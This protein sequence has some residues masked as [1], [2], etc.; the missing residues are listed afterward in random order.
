[1]RT[2]MLAPSLALALACSA[3]GDS[4]PTAKTK[5]ADDL[6]PTD[7]GADSKTDGEAPGPGPGDGGSSGTH[8]GS[9]D[10]S[11][12]DSATCEE[13]IIVCSDFV[14]DDCDG[15]DEPCP[16]TQSAVVIPAWDCR[17]NPPAGVVAV[18][19]FGPKDCVAF[20]ES[21]AGAI[22]VAPLREEPAGATSCPSFDERR[23]AFTL[24]GDSAECPGIDIAADFSENPELAVQPVSNSCRK[25]LHAMSQPLSYAAAN[26]KALSARVAAFETLE[27]ACV[28]Y[29]DWPYKWESLLRAPIEM[30]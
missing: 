28:G 22:Y 16:T 11:H 4:T 9:S 1:M 23:Y 24:S 30:L 7:S 18:A 10:A 21:S 17:G 29:R 6:P 15:K 14:D 5:V 25:F 20:F 27:L 2:S 8:S 26:R 3:C 12:G 13:E 19:R